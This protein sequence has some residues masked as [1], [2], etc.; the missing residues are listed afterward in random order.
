MAA[1]PNESMPM[2]Q[3]DH[4]TAH[5]DTKVDLDCNADTVFSNAQ[6]TAQ[7]TAQA[8]KSP[9]THTESLRLGIINVESAQL[10]GEKMRPIA[11]L[12]GDEIMRFIVEQPDAKIGMRCEVFIH[13]AQ[14]F[15]YKRSLNKPIIES[16]ESIYATI[17][18]TI[19]ESVDNKVLVCIDVN[20][21]LLYRYGKN[22]YKFR[23][24]VR[25]FM[26][27]L[28]DNFKVIVWSSGTEKNIRPLLVKI[29]GRDFHRLTDIWY[30]D[31]CT[32]AP[33]DDKWWATKKDISKLTLAFPGHAVVVIE[34]NDDKHTGADPESYLY[35]PIT[36]FKGDNNDNELVI[37]EKNL[38]VFLDNY[39]TLNGMSSELTRANALS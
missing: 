11:V 27:F 14:E 39:N 30:R 32:P 2:V 16:D 10:Y 31:K 9:N 24:H 15:V 28:L 38:K 36:P 17:S 12:N 6:A 25:R 29:L 13:L 34:D 7:A 37:M 18:K 5:A 8:N 19:N 23:P 26:K 4:L 3:P 21:T 22:N 35:L 33:S 20:E 1:R